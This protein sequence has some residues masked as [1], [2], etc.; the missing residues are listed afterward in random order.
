MAL[1]GNTAQER[2]WN[3]FMSKRVGEY[4]TAGIMASIRAE[5]AF[6]PKNLQ[7]SCE[8][9]SGYTDATYTCAVDNGTYTNF[10]KD[11]FGYGYAQWTYWSRK[12]NLLNYAKQQAK[13]IGD[14]EMQL[15]FI[16]IELSGAYKGVLS[17]LKS[18][19]SV[20]E[21]SDIILTG[22]EKPK[23]QGESAKKMRGGYAEEYYNRFTSNKG[24][25]IMKIIIGSA[26]RDENGNYTG[27]KAGDQDGV[28]VSTQDYYLHKKGWYLYR[29]LSEEHAQKLAQ[30]MYDACMNNNIG[31]C[32]AH[33][34]IMTMLKKY[35]SM[36]AIGEKTETDCSNLVRGCIYQA[37]GIDVGNFN[38]ASEPGILDKS[39][40]F[41]K[42][43]SVTS[44]TR[45]QEGDI[46]VTKTKGHTVIVISVDGETAKPTVQETNPANIK[47]NSA[48]SKLDS[49]AGNY[50]TTANLNLRTGAGK[51]KTSITI[52]PV[53]KTVKCYG[54]YTDVNGTKWLLVVYN[55]MTGFCSSAYLKRV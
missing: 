13:S 53:G 17:K 26:R 45:L 19:K 44:M 29:A 31:Y 25:A 38:T 49:L 39:G 6:N 14:E 36:K 21:A 18:A 42:K 15:N 22:Y 37:T 8:K 28:E 34:A 48:K 9:K 20:Q 16:W 10:V 27:R 41:A 52:I 3:F 7:N 30:A 1:K 55:G 23:D 12:Q 4:G 40:L 51:D 32:Q 47:I 11:S 2:A 35:G 54:Y 5:S 33:R 43:Q 46:L 24:G 50:V